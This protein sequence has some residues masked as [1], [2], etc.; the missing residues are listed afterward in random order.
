MFQRVVSLAALSLPWTATA[1]GAGG[2]PPSPL[3]H[4]PRAFVTTLTEP[5]RN[6]EPSIAIDPNNPLHVVAAY[7]DNAHAAFSADGG[8][9]WT[10]VS[11]VAPAD[12]RVS[13]D[14][15]VT[16]DNAGHA[17][18]CFIAFDRLGTADYWAHDATRNGILVRR[19]L[20]GGAAWETDYRVIDAW[21]TASGIP[22]EDKPYIV[23]DN[24]RG[25]YA[26]NLYV[27]WTQFTLDSS[28]ILLSRSTD[29]GS[30]WSKALRVS[31]AAGLPRDDNGSVEGFAGAVG[32]D[33]TLYAVWA[34]G[35][36]VVFTSSRDGGRT[37]ARSRPIIETAAS[38]FKVTGVDRANGFP[39][40]AVDPR[41]NRLY[42]AWSDYRY[43]DVDVFVATS[44]D[45]GRTWT[46]PV[47]VNT[48]SLH[49]GRDQ[50]FQWLAVDPADGAA[51]VLFYDRRA[52]T[53][54]RHAILVLARSTDG[55]RSFANFAWTDTAFDARDE[56]LGDYTGVAALDG[57]V[58]G[59]WA[60]VD[61]AAAA[62]PAQL[63]R[64]RHAVIR[65]GVAD[66]GRV[67]VQR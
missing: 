28:I 3:P 34:D 52:D 35:T 49:N 39:E 38:Y 11:S 62:A 37:F 10:I 24:T 67:P 12:Y 31:T 57:R 9:T 47:R 30:T 23:A 5:G 13:G 60:E 33:G 14:V 29:H 59:I 26:G 50:F 53:T 27:G 55:G 40:V 54:N 51:N 32:A 48:D 36:H 21:P 8:H 56:F 7:Q 6:T 1:A 45:R 16:F 15:S 43:G 4:P 44:N 22:F 64:A 58:Y 65:I 66:F 42:V 63:P 41:T 19:S 25:P 46:P 20:D 61:S 2:T 18:L 17:L